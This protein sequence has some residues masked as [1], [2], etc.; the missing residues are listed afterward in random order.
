MPP[1]QGFQRRFLRSRAHGLRPLVQVG[2]AGPTDAV[3]AAVDEALEAHELVKVRLL[4]P[5]DKRALAAALAARMG[6]E[7][8]GLVGHTVILYRRHPEAPRLEIPERPAARRTRA[9]DLS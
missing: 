9:P 7:L 1:L 4:E 8:C 3:L 5:E 2:A 6:A